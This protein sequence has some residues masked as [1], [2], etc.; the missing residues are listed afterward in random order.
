TMSLH[1][2][3]RPST[4]HSCHWY[5]YSIPAWVPP[6]FSCLALSSSRTLMV[7]A[8]FGW[9]SFTGSAAS[10]TLVGAEVACVEPPEF[11]AVT[12]RR[13]ADL[14]RLSVIVSASSLPARFVQASPAELHFCHW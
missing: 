6:H 3:T 1:S 9:I 4:P 12:T 11:F 13:T 2:P 7:P 14:I 10:T 8:I 5:L